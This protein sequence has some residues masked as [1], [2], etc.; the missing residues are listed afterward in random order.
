[1]KLTDIKAFISKRLGTDEIH[2][3]LWTERNQ[4]DY[5]NTRY[6]FDLLLAK[7]KALTGRTK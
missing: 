4:A 1:M 6:E 2:T 3:P 7:A 5:D